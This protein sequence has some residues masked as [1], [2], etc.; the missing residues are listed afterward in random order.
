V[1]PSSV[2]E[3][4][5]VPVLVQ[6][7]FPLAGV[8]VNDRGKLPYLAE[9][10]KS[11]WVPTPCMDGGQPS[12][13]QLLAMAVIYPV[14]DGTSNVVEVRWTSIPGTPPKGFIAGRIATLATLIDS[15]DIA[16]ISRV[17]AVQEPEAPPL[18]LKP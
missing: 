6:L 16:A 2:K 12:A 17:V 10:D 14:T 4:M 18:I 7:R 3:Y 13:T 8:V 15:R 1:E 9:P 5:G 11:Q